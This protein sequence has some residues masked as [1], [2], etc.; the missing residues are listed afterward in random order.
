MIEEAAGITKFKA[1]KRESQRKLLSTE[2][3]LIRLHDIVNELKRQIDSL[4]RQAQRAERYRNLKREADDLDMW[5][6]SRQY[7][8]LRAKS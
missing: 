1:R 6:T 7:L 3:N 4:E 5:L 8:E 2:Q